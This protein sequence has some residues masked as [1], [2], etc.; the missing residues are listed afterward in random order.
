MMEF[1][2]VR[3]YSEGFTVTTKY[4]NEYLEK[5]WKVV[6]VNPFIRNGNTYYLE[7]ILKKPNQG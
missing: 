4:L 2:A 1:I 7:Y 3:S 5:G 6:C